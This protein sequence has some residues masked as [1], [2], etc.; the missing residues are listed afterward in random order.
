MWLADFAT[1][2]L[3]KNQRAIIGLIRAVLAGTA[4]LAVHTDTRGAIG[5]AMALMAVLKAAERVAAVR[6]RDAHIRHQLVD[7]EQQNFASRAQF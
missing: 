2:E 7:F 3:A 6:D 1:H 4:Q 5:L